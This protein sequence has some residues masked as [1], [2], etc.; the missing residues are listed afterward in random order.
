MSTLVCLY[1]QSFFNVTA[2]TNFRITPVP[3]SGLS[4]AAAI[5]AGEAHS[6]AIKT[7]PCVNGDVNRDGIV[8]AA[9]LAA[10]AAAF[11]TRPPVNPHA[12]LN[13]D[14]IVNIFDLAVVAMNFGRI[15]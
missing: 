13:G 8:N 1:I 4:G 10:V 9:D 14:G 2:T 7:I 12:D 5:A 15:L 11:N 6:L 3:V